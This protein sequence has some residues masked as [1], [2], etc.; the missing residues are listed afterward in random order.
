MGGRGERDK[1]R[2]GTRA[3]SL[4][5]HGVAHHTGCDGH[6]VITGVT[7]EEEVV[8]N[9]GAPLKP[10]ISQACAVHPPSSSSPPLDS[11]CPDSQGW[12]GMPLMGVSTLNTVVAYLR[13]AWLGG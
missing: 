10:C 5:G 12:G 6:E 3:D 9:T 8:G 1:G 13:P 2:H 4:F 7:K 11:S